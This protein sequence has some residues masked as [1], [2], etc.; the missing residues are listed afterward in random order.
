MDWNHPSLTVALPIVAAMLI[1]TLASI[2]SYSK[3]MDQLG[4][5]IDDLR[6]DMNARFAAIEKRLDRLENKI[7]S[8]QERSWR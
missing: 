4:K 3:G 2:R 6:T 5:R 1:A 7:E 8:I